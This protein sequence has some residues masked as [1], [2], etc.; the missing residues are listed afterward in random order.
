MCISVANQ[1][2]K[3]FTITVDAQNVFLLLL[4]SSVLKKYGS[5]Y[6]CS[7]NGT[8]HTNHLIVKGHL[9]S[10][11]WINTAPVPIVLNIDIPNQMEPVCFGSG[12][13]SCIAHKSQLLKTL[14]STNLKILDEAGT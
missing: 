10:L 14:F 13:L 2:F 8:P 7:S 5:C 11:S 12:T 4:I 1:F 6:L 3:E 9:T